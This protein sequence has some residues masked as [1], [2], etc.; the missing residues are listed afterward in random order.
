MILAVDAGNSRIKWGLYDADWVAQGAVDTARAGELAAAWTALPQPRAAIGSS[1]AGASARA[2]VE[3]ALAAWSLEPRWITAQAAQCGVRSGYDDAG[4]LGPDRWAALIGARQRER[5]ACLV[6][7][8]GTATTIDA[9]SGDGRFLG[10]VIVPGVELMREALARSTAALKLQDGAVRPLPTN[11]GDAIASGAVHALAGAIE[12]LA[13]FMRNAGEPQPICVLSGGG[14]DLL[15][16]H[17]AGVVR[18]VENLVL[19]GLIAI[20]AEPGD[21]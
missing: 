21:R 2:A 4:Q 5:G 15:A 7:C 1:V 20:A 9:L 11:T 8:A 14:A 18:R 16:P 10:G 19:E 13:A 6:V 17:V 3:R 12:R